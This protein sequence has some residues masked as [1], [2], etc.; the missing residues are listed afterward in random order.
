M[1]NRKPKSYTYTIKAA[2]VSTIKTI[3]AT[4]FLLSLIQLLFMIKL[5]DKAYSVDVICCIMV[6]TCLVL[7]MCCMMSLPT[8]LFDFSK[9]KPNY[10]CYN[11]C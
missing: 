3:H 8:P 1:E 11:E 10:E 7:S 2:D 5:A 9:M 4:I 6:I